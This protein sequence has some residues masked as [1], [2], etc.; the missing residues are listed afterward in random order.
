MVK[1]L[2][3][4]TSHNS[5]AASIEEGGIIVAVNEERSVREK[6]FWELPKNSIKEV[7]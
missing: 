5:S 3:I 1:I 6:L 4:H 2:G 7:F